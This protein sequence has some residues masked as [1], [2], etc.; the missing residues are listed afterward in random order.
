MTTYTSPF[1]VDDSFGNWLAGFIAGEG[2]FRIASQKQGNWYAPS[3]H[4]KLR[5]DDKAI[6]DECARRVGG[7]VYR[8]PAYKTSNPGARWCCQSRADCIALASVLDNYPLRNR[9]AAEY[10]VWREAL[11]IY[12]KMERGNRWRGPRDWTPLIEAKR[13]IAAQ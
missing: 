7:R 5:D 13:E 12:G 2:C 10:V 3:F 9:K 6:L 8:M 11:D 1:P 4:L